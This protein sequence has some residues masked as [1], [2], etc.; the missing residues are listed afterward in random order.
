MY[1][2]SGGYDGSYLLSSTETWTRGSSAWTPAADLP[3]PRFLLA[4]VTI[5]GQF[6][7]TG[8][9]AGCYNIV[10]IIYCIF[11]ILLICVNIIFRWLL[12][13]KLSY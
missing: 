5:G 11:I 2:V 9:L 6:L 12:Q 4:G 8:E 7:V 1:I 10:Y 13:V 3:S